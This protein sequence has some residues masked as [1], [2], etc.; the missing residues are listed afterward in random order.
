MLWQDHSEGLTAGVTAEQVSNYQLGTSER[1]PGSC[2]G[3]CSQREVTAL[4]PLHSQ[5]FSG[6]RMHECFLSQGETPGS[7]L[8]PQA[9]THRQ[10]RAPIES[11]RSVC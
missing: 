7:S 8:R 11:K 10:A 1:E 3:D 6:V 5:G 4:A 9:A 2:P